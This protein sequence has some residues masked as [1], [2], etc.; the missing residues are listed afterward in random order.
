LTSVE[1]QRTRHGY[2]EIQIRRNAVSAMG[3]QFGNMGDSM[4]NRLA[5]FATFF[6]TIGATLALT[7]TSASA[8]KPPPQPPPNPCIDAQSRGFPALAFT[9]QRTTGGHVY[10]D[11]ILSDLTGQCQK[12]IYVADGFAPSRVGSD[13]NLRYRYSAISATTGA[14]LVVRSDGGGATFAASTYTVTFDASGAP[15]FSTL[16]DYSTV[17]ALA[18]LNTAPY[19]DLVGWS[20]YVMG[21]PLISPDG[22]KMLASVLFRKIQGTVETVLS[23]IWTCPFIS[24]PQVSVDAANCQMVYHGSAGDNGPNASWGAGSTSLYITDASTAGS[25]RVLSRLP[26]D[27]LIPTPLWNLGTM[28]SASRGG[29]ITIDSKELVAVYEAGGTTGCSRVWVINANNCSNGG[30]EVLNGG[31]PA[32]TM[33]W[34]PNGRLAGEGQTAPNRKG[35]CSS[36]GSIVGFDPFDSNPNTT[37][38]TPTGVQPDG[39]GGG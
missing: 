1:K 38:I 39:A 3:M 6:A 7:G 19:A 14:G 34:L 23:T 15:T 26:L 37:T 25:G 30:C 21:K 8:G 33:T 28:F 32:R 27:T 4:M 9:R 24:S 20:T 18:D 36:T 5:V 11:T 29:P 10:Y 16:G 2:S 12:T 13:V 17:L 22:T 35:Q 31:A